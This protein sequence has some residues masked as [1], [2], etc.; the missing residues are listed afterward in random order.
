MDAKRGRAVKTPP[1]LPRLASFRMD[2]REYLDFLYSQFMESLVHE[3][4]PWKDGL[5]RVRLRR[6][7]EV[8]GRHQCFWHIVSGSED[9]NSERTL[10]EE[11]CIR[12][13]WVRYFIDE[14]TSHYPRYVDIL[15]WID[16]KR[17]RHPRYV[18]SNSDFSFVVIVEERPTYALLVT[19]F[20]V[21]RDRRRRKFQ[22]EFIAFWQKQKPLA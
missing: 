21:E 1:M 9:K 19:A 20:H 8:D 5:S 7:P 14:F 4:P 2:E 16:R 6:Y 12:L 3:A 13:P 22:D 11:R 18:L 15:W 17:A 10:D